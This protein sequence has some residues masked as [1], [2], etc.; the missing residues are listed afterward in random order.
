MLDTGLLV[1]VEISSELSE[2]TDSEP[3]DAL[4]SLEMLEKPDSL[5]NEEVIVWLASVDKL[6]AVDMLVSPER[7]DTDCSDELVPGSLVDST[8]LEESSVLVALDDSEN[9]IEPLVDWPSALSL[10]RGVESDS[11]ESCVVGR[12]SDDSTLDSEDTNEVVVTE[13]LSGDV[14]IFS[15]VCEN[16]LEKLDIEA[17]VD[18][19]DASDDSVEVLDRMD[20]LDELPGIMIT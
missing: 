10:D 15:V 11:V 3:V 5:V 1:P 20:E 13:L 17:E 19:L 6:S 4:V 14:D 18:P 8:R 7:L 12:V 2:L 16:V 9:D